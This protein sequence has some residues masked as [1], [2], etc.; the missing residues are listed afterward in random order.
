VYLR[1]D[2]VD[3]WLADSVNKRVT[4]HRTSAAAAEQI[5]AQGVDISTSRIG[6]F[7]LG[8]YTATESDPF[9]G[10]VEIAVAVRTVRPLVGDLDAIEALM[11]RLA[12][13]FG[14]DRLTPEVAAAIRRELLDSGYDGIVVRDAGGDGVDYVI[15]LD[16]SSVR[17]VRP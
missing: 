5:I 1:P 2:E 13:R 4:Y 15:A 10:P 11:D 3:A 6:S 16:E 7:G 8:F 14:R 17:V 9:Y 12:A